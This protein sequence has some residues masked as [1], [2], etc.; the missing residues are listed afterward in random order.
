[1]NL[2]IRKKKTSLGITGNTN[3]GVISILYLTDEKLKQR[4]FVS[5]S[6]FRAM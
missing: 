6:L 5:T 4:A 2:E 1:M 3:V